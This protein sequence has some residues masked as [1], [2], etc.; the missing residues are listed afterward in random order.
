V[1]DEVDGTLQ[2]GNRVSLKFPLLC[3]VARESP[4]PVQQRRKGGG[5]TPGRALWP[6]ARGA[7]PPFSPFFTAVFGGINVDVGVMEGAEEQGERR[8]R[9]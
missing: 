7:F 2:E 5:N 6:E 3:P 4:C 9:E 1:E 8:G